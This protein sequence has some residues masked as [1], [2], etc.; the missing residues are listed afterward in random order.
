MAETDQGWWLPIRE[1]RHETIEKQQALVGLAREALAVRSVGLGPVPWP[2]PFRPGTPLGKA[3]PSSCP[4]GAELG[5]ERTALRRIFV[6]CC[7]P[8]L[9]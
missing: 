5:T 6:R 8:A 4:F 7:L 1:A 3:L 9:R 2:L